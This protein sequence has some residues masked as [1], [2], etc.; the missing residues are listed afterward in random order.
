M[1]RPLLVLLVAHYPQCSQCTDPLTLRLR[2]EDHTAA[3]FPP[4]RRFPPAGFWQAG[5]VLPLA[6][7]PPR[8]AVDFVATGEAAMLGWFPRLD[9]PNTR[10]TPLADSHSLVRLLGSGES[11]K[12]TPG[13]ANGDVV[14]RDPSS[15]T[16]HTLWEL[17]WSR[18]DPWV[19]ASGL[20]HPILVL[21]NVPWGFCDP[22]K[23]S[24]AGSLT[25]GAKYGM[26]YGP[27]NCT[28]YGEWIET[29]LEAM[30]SRYGHARASE[31]WFRVGTEPNTRPGHWND[32]NSK[33]YN[34]A[35][36]Q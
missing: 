18:L 20:V 16:L 7:G 11:A 17:L 13:E 5:P 14:L 30:V 8:P 23:C 34:H 29:L 3:A 32:T 1:R 22:R 6:K 12:G 35:S 10:I 9:A 19:N 33:V 28:E 4:G 27:A 24:S 21:D 25:P 2:T 15:G 31:F 26:D 36:T